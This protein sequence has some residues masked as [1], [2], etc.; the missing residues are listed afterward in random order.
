MKRWL[1]AAAACVLGVGSQSAVAATQIVNGSGIL[2]G[3]TGVVVNGVSYDVH[4]VGGTCESVYGGCGLST[5]DFTDFNTAQAAGKALL[6]QVYID[7]PLGS[8]GSD[9]SKTYGCI[10]S[11]E[12]YSHIAFQVLHYGEGTIQVRR[13]LPSSG[14]ANTVGAGVWLDDDT[15]FF[16][17]NNFVRFSLSSAGSVPEPATWAMMLAGFGAIGGMLRCRWR[18]SIRRA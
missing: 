3:A 13:F 7:T 17:P 14:Q 4:I 9:P 10:G 2:T 18:S 6:D 8:F 11:R 16:P 15:D 12:C 1:I 5:F